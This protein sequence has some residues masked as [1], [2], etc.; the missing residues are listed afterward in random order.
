MLIDRWL[1]P[2]E[3][4]ERC[5]VSSKTLR[6]AVRA[7]RFKPAGHSPGGHARYLLSQV[8]EFLRLMQ[9]PKLNRD[10]QAIHDHVRAAQAKLRAARRRA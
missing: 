4:A 8:G 3:F 5:G 10:A 7:G 9:E 6:R 2:G 1:R